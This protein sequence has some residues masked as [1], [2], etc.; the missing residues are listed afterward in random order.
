[1]IDHITLRVSNIEQ[2]LT[3]YRA[4]LPALE[5][6]LKFDHTFGTV[7]VI[8]FGKGS[9]IDTWFTNDLPQGGPLH[10]AW[11]AASKEQVNDF[12][13]RALEAGGKDNGAP[14]LRPEYHAQYYGAFVIDP[15]GNNIEAVCHN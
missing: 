2:V 1:M 12:Y 14:G 7:R 15:H 3:F 5:Y 10:I 4:V 6:T 11:T 9:T 13:R 8:G